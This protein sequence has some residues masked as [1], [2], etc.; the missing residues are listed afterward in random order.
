MKR[1]KSSRFLG[2]FGLFLVF[3]GV[4]VGLE[5]DKSRMRRK[6]RATMVANSLFFWPVVNTEC[7]Q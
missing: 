2:V 4:F 5:L 6:R 1:G 7:N 3:T